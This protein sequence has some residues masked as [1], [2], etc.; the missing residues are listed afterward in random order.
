[1]KKK[2]FAEQ[3]P[4]YLPTERFIPNS[5]HFRRA[6]LAKPDFPHQKFHDRQVKENAFALALVMGITQERGY[7]FANTGQLEPSD[8]HLGSWLFAL[9]MY[10]GFEWNKVVAK[11]VLLHSKDVLPRSAPVYAWI[12]QAADRAAGM[13]WTG[14]LRDAYYLGFR[15]P[16]LQVV[17]KLRSPRERE[18]QDSIAAVQKVCYEDAFPFLISHGLASKMVRKYWDH[19]HQFFGLPD[20]RGGWKV[21]PLLPIAQEIFYDLF[22]QTEVFTLLLAEKDL[23]RVFGPTILST[24]KNPSALA[25]LDRILDRN[26]NH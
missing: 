10:E 20:G 4:I 9:K 26:P 25:K 24:L 3:F 21:G 17:E 15:H 7:G 22:A 18:Y 19:R 6:V 1:M 12:L 13:G 11:T 14:I 23:V 2:E 16:N 5:P 8:H